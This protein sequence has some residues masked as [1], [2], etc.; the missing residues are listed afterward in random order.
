MEDGAVLRDVDVLAAEHRVA[1]LGHALFV[2]ELPKQPQRLVGDPVLG[3]VEEE[4]GALADQAGASIGVLGEQPPEVPPRDLAVV[5]LQRLPCRALAELRFRAHPA[6]PS[7][8]AL[9]ASSSSCT[10]S[11][12]RSPPGAFSSSCIS[13]SY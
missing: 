12:P 5:L 8:A 4:A 9:T 10:S 11:S 13:S 1:P 2:G 3:V 6:Q 7:Y